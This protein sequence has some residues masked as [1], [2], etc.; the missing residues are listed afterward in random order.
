VDV[1]VGYERN[2][3]REFEEEGASEVALGLLSRTYNT[4]VRL[5]HPPVA[6]MAGILGVT[7][8][9]NEFDKFGE[10]TLVPTNAYNNVGIYAFEQLETGRWNF[11]LGARYD[12]RRLNVEDDAELGV[13]AQRRT[14]NSVTGNLGVLYRVAEPIAL[15]LN[16]GRGF[17][18]PTAFDLFSNGV[19]EGTVRFERGDSTLGNETS[20]NT[21]LAFRIQGRKVTMEVGGF[22]NLIDNFIF[23]DP[24]GEIDP[25]SGLQIFDIT[26]GNARLTGLEAAVEFHPAP[27]LHVRGTADYTRGQNTT[28]DIP[29]P[30]IPAFRATYGVR[31][32]GGEGGWVQHP[33]L[34]LGAESNARQTRLDP[35]DFAPEGYT[36]VNIGGGVGLALGE[37]TVGIDLQLRNVF[38]KAYTSFLSR[39]K[40]YALDPGRNLIIR[41][42]TSI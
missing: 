21:D 39:Y 28:T 22:V 6:G 25:E 16:V 2:R 8:L 14:W 23:P 34:S 1:H 37:R 32:E 30:F 7:G 36:L 38:D 3:R 41:I 12:H 10:E 24:S 20:L 42:S 31:L 5:H 19:H 26:Q 33:Y 11:A 17:R 29:L 18:A 9:R 40:T 13:V 27:F 15:V 35:N 4:D